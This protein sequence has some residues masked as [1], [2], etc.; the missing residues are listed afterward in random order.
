MTTLQG[1]DYVVIILFFVVILFAGLYSSVSKF[2]DPKNSETSAK[3]YFL[4]DKSMYWVAVGA[5]LFCSNIGSEHL[6]GLAGTGAKSGKSTFVKYFR[7]AC[8]LV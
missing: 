8:R 5:S 7:V 3:E 1:P 4:A 6:I 2:L